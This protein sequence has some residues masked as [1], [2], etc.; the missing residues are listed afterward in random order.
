MIFSLLLI[1]LFQ[2]QKEEINTP[3]LNG[4]YETIEQPIRCIK[5]TDSTITSWCPSY[6]FNGVITEKYSLKKENGKIFIIFKSDSPDNKSCIKKI[7]TKIIVFKS[8]GWL[9]GTWKRFI[10]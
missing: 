9:N 5:I 1:F 2:H 8:I 4:E 7:T 6:I 3:L 10:Y